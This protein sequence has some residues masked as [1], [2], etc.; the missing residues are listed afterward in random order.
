MSSNVA[1]NVLRVRP[2][3]LAS[4][5]HFYTEICGMTLTTSEIT[6]NDQVYS[7]YEL[8]FPHNILSSQLMFQCESSPF[9]VDTPQ[10]GY[11]KI[12]FTVRD[13]DSA[14]AHL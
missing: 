3:M 12:G 13:L 2:D 7:R 6:E 14:V 10:A 8:T 5:L 9:L 4:T 1:S 11:W